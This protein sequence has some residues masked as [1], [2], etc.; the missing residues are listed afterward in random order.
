MVVLW[1]IA[2]AV[3]RAEL[4]FVGGQLALV[5]KRKP[6]RPGFRGSL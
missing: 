6:G 5:R 2:M 1:H 3:I 4:G